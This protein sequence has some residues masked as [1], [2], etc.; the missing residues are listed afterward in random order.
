MVVLGCFHKSVM[1]LWYRISC[2]VLCPS[3]GKFF[4]QPWSCCGA[5]FLKPSKDTVWFPF[6]ATMHLHYI[7]ADG[8]P[9]SGFRWVVQKGL[10]EEPCQPNETS[11]TKVDAQLECGVQ[12]LECGVQVEVLQ[13]VAI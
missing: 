5:L 9:E 8:C 10:A 6:V 1:E 13:Y 7:G 4:W 11:E 12:V 2:N 3:P